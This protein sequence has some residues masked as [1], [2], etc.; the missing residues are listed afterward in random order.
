[1]KAQQPLIHACVSKAIRLPTCRLRDALHVPARVTCVAVTVLVA[2]GALARA[3]A[4]AGKIVVAGD[5]WA[6]SDDGFPNNPTYTTNVLKWFG[7]TPN[8]SG[9]KVMVLDG[10]SWN[11]GYGGTYGAFGSVFRSLLTGMGVTVTYL[12][13]TD[14]LVS[15]GGYDAVF[16]AGRMVKATTLT[17]DLATFVAGGGAV[18][19]A[20]GT[21]T[22]SPADAATEAAYW[23]SFLTAATGSGDFGLIGSNGWFAE[24]PPLQVAGPVGE[25]VAVLKWYLG[26]GVQVGSNPN[27]SAAIWDS[28][29]TLV[30]TW[31]APLGTPVHL[32][33]VQFTGSDLAFSFPTVN[34]RLYVVQQNTN[35]ATADW[36]Y[37]T[38]I[39]GDGSLYQLLVPVSNIQQQFLRISQP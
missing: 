18:Y 5:E 33:S 14:D 16:L 7:L 23:Q 39:T 9:K 22:F 28:S 30:A 37:F 27:A 19:L 11:S 36:S 2:F 3:E 20:G 4:A 35:L 32:Q 24:S 1:M 12:G 15:L 10:Q 6:F 21:G 29:N 26:Q 17:N 38:N 13:Y 25:G 8:G 34:G 31:S